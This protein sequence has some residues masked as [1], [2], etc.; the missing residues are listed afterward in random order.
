MKRVA[1]QMDPLATLQIEG[2]S[3]FALMLEA[4]ARGYQLFTYSPDNLSYQ[5]SQVTAWAQVA[6]VRDAPGNH[7]CLLYT[8]PSPRD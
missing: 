6:E 4:Q 5:D 7:A 3:T 2:D 8:S 1:F